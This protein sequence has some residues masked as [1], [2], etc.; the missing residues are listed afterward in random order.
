MPRSFSADGYQPVSG[1]ARDEIAAATGK[2]TMASRSRWVSTI[3]ALLMSFV[4]VARPFPAEA[5]N[6][7][8]FHLLV[9]GAAYVLESTC[10]WDVR[11]APETECV[12]SFVIYFQE[13]HPSD[14]HVRRQP[15]VLFVAETR[16]I[17]HSPDEPDTVL[18]ERFGT[19]E[20]A[21]GSVDTTHLMKATVA[22]SVPMDDGSTFD[23]DLRWDM[24]GRPLNVAGT[25]GPILEEG[26]PW[27]SHVVDRCT[28]ENWH[29]HQTW[30]DGGELS[31]D[32]D[33][34]D[35]ASLLFPDFYPPFVG[36]GVFTIA[37]SSHGPGCS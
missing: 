30:R 18:H 10:P 1:R 13:G 14:E 16:Y 25:D 36:R 28:T 22:D 8:T 23:V 34:T 5:T 2:A 4:L 19:L 12:D 33:G 7:E 21:L 15:W 20:G 37:I 6:V 24:S 29:A 35:V 31:G 3:L 9:T 32:L 11:P 26:V 27:G 17:F